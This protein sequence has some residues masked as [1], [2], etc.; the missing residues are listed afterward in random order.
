MTLQIVCRTNEK[1]RV[2]ELH[3]WLGKPEVVE[4]HKVCASA[5][6][7]SLPRPHEP[8][9]GQRRRDPGSQGG[10]GARRSPRGRVALRRSLAPRPAPRGTRVMRT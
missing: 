2:I 6:P 4:L 3:G 7:P 9:V 8:D 1:E 5:S 10:A